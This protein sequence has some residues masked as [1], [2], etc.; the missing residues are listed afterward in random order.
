MT[1][2]IITC[3]ACGN[4]P[5]Y[6]EKSFKLVFP[7]KEMPKVYVGS[8]DIQKYAESLDQK[9]NITKYLLALARNKEKYSYYFEYSENGDLIA[10]YNLLNGRR[11]A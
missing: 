11:I 6:T 3:C 1:R 9:M 8:S 4:V 7:D 10:Q 5:D 2:E